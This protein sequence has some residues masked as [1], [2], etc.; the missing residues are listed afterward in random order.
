MVFLAPPSSVILKGFNTGFIPVAIFSLLL[1]YS[2]FQSGLAA[3]RI[4]SG[5]V[6]REG[7]A[8]LFPFLFFL[9]GERF[10]GSH[11][12]TWFTLGHLANS[13][14]SEQAPSHFTYS[15]MSSSVLMLSEN[16][17]SSYLDALIHHC[18]CIGTMFEFFFFELLCIFSC[19]IA[20]PP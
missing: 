1:V 3:A 12:F 4:T 16:V 7:M 11:F 2:A 10:P 15:P 6:I 8:P 5:E 13:H 20:L 18:Q 14:W 17:F 9:K 19:A